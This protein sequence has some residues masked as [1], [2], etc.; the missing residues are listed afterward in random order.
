MTQSK[1]EKIDEVDKMYIDTC[2][3]VGSFS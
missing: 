3:L 2:V 1:L